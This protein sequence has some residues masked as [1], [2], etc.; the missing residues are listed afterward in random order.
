MTDIDIERRAQAMSR[1][2]K[3]AY[4]IDRGW[5]KRHDHKWEDWA[6]GVALSFDQRKRA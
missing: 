4:L 3:V 5:R 6:T 2:R 1:G